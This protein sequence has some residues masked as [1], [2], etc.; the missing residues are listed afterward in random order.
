MEANDSLQI[1]ENMIAKTKGNIAGRSKYFLL[2]GWAVFITTIVQYILIRMLVPNACLVWC[3]M[4]IAG[5]ITIIWAIR[6][7]KYENSVTYTGDAIRKLWQS[8]GIA[9]FFIAF[10]T[11]QGAVSS[12]PAFMLIYGIGILT[13]GRILQ[14][15]PMIAGGI[16]CFIGCLLSVVLPQD[17]NQL[18]LFAFVVL[19][20]YILPGHLLAND[21]KKQQG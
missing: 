14:F 5:L 16:I 3:S 20:S 6:D 8:I 1:I 10:L 9:C 12:I 13:S 4:F 11:I 7:K 17:A 2:W 21:S 19:S 15:K 18:L